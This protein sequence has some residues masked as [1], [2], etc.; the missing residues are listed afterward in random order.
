MLK[1]ENLEVSYGAMQALRGISMEVADGEIVSLIGANG[2]GKTTTLHAVTG[3]VPIKTGSVEYDGHDLRKIDP[4]KIVSMGLAHVPEGRQVFTRMTVAENLAMGAYHRKDKKGI[5]ADLEHVYE[6]FPRLKER[7][8]QLAGTL[9][10]GEQQMVAMGRAIMSAPKLVVMDEPS[11]GLSPVLVKEVFDIIRTMHES[12]IT[13]LL[14]EH[15]AKMALAISN[16]AYVLEN[17]RITMSGD[18]ST[19]LH[20]DKVRKAYLGA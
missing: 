12:G 19:L 4:S 2:A 8:K 15:N 9:S 7:A 6:R 5:E 3:L 11:M 16:R 13:I 18:A 20:D 1:I 14:V 10:G 17:G